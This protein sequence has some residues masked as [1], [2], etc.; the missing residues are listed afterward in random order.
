MQG[1]RC[2]GWVPDGLP[3]GEGRPGYRSDAV[4]YPATVVA[5]MRTNTLS[6]NQPWLRNPGPLCEC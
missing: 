4:T 2:E 3:L 1:G 6:P 5:T